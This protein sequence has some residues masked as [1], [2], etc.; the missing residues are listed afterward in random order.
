MQYRVIVTRRP[1][2]ACRAC[3]GVVL[4]HA[5][6][7][8]QGGLATERLI[9]HVI[10]AKYHRHLPLYRQ[11]QVLATHNIA[12]DRSTLAFRVGYA[13]QT[14]KRMSYRRIVCARSCLCLA[15]ALNR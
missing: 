8:R 5:A 13:A 3:H 10:D 9:A 6:P 11:A 14:L 15:K 7:D 1:K 12:I 4:Q 2:L